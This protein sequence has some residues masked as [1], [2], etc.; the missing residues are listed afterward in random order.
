MK[1]FL[2]PAIFLLIESLGSLRGGFRYLDLVR[3]SRRAP[4][5]NYYPSVAV[6]IPCKGIDDDLRSNATRFLSQDYPAYQLIFAVASQDDP[7]YSFLADLVA[8]SQHGRERAAKAR[9]IVAG[10]A[11]SNGEKV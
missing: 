3:K 5:G 9:V 10:Q 2:I 1:L 4:L 6:I 11:E 8:S 7:A